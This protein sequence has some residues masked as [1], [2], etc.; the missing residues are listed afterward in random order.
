VI[1]VV[2]RVKALCPTVRYGSCA[3]VPLCRGA[4]HRR[5]DVASVTLAAHDPLPLYYHARCCCRSRV[6][7]GEAV[8]DPVLGDEGMF[9]VPE[10]HVAI[11]R[12]E[13]IP[14]ATIVTPN[15]FECE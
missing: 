1:A 8:C 5:R 14:L 15:Q 12:D 11:Y 2:N 3:G 6:C 4:E 9:Y 7:C 10:E 13:V